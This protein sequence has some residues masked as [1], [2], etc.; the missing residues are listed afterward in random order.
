MD[1]SDRLGQIFFMLQKCSL[2]LQADSKIGFVIWV[3]R[4]I[5]GSFLST[6][7]QKEA[8]AKIQREFHSLYTF[9]YH[10]QW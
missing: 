2:Y 8:N 6:V 5:K 1:E 10:L 7:I 4:H 9:S 3:K